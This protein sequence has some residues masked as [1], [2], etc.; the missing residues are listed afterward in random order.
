MWG[1][2][3]AIAVGGAAGSVCRYGMLQLT[4]RWWSGSFPFGTLFVNVVGCFIIGLMT[5]ALSAYWVDKPQ[6]RALIT[7]GFLGGFTTFS[8]FAWDVGLL[9][10]RSLW[11][12]AALYVALSILLSL[13][14]YFAAVWLVGGLSS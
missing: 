10:E 3:L 2:I 7:T 11:G 8:A 14:A 12:S 6:L 4:G 9:S 5:A 13:G 1:T